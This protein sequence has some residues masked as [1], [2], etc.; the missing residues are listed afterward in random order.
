MIDASPCAPG[1]PLSEGGLA[2]LKQE[3]EQKKDQVR[4]L[5]LQLQS[6]CP[7]RDAVCQAGSALEPDYESECNFESAVAIEE[8]SESDANCESE[9]DPDDKS[10]SKTTHES[11]VKLEN[12]S[13]LDF[14]S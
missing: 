8:A 7:A 1:G 4:V 9:V 3:L 2:V 13:E 6:A 10:E 14:W 12:M 5:Q 11:K